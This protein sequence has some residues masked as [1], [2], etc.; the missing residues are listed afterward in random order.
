MEKRIINTSKYFFEK[1]K[2]DLKGTTV[3]FYDG[4]HDMIND[5]CQERHDNRKEIAK[6][7]KYA[8][9]CVKLEPDYENSM[10]ISSKKISPFGRTELVIVDMDTI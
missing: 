9:G 6:A 10:H 1:S 5:N 8:G 4:Y 3:Y 2:F 7:I